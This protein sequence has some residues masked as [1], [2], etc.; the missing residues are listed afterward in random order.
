MPPRILVPDGGQRDLTAVTDIRQSGL[1]GARRV[2][3][4]E[5]FERSSS[6][7][8]YQEVGNKCAFFTVS[9]PK[10]MENIRGPL[11]S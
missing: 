11:F 7:L 8:R 3:H 6:S 4:T 1:R 2:F 10:I 5:A 9:R